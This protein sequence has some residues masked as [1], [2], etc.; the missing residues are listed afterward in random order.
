ML[1]ET[2]AGLCLGLQCPL[3]GLAQGTWLLT[4]GLGLG[5]A[6]PQG[7]G[8]SGEWSGDWDGCWVGALAREQGDQAGAGAGRLG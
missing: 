7:L 1:L 6:G 5:P 2:E 8:G 4:R 3:W